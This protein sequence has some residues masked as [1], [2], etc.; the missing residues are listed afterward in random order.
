MGKRGSWANGPH[1][2]QLQAATFPGQRPTNNCRLQTGTSHSP[3]GQGLVIGTGG[4]NAFHLAAVAWRVLSSTGAFAAPA[5]AR[6][7]AGSS[8]VFSCYLTSLALGLCCALGMCAERGRAQLP[9]ALTRVW[10]GLCESLGQRPPVSW[11]RA[12]RTA[13]QYMKVWLELSLGKLVRLGGLRDPPLLPAA[14]S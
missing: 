4:E 1:P 7:P 10:L 6:P 14:P 13:P 11:L 12:R 8:S 5:G 2:P 9:R 3:H